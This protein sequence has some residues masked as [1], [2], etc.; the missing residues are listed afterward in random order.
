MGHENEKKLTSQQEKW[1]GRSAHFDLGIHL[2]SE[3]QF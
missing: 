3:L 1:N 2:R